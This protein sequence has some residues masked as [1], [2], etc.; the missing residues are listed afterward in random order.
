MLHTFGVVV[1]RGIA[2]GIDLPATLAQQISRRVITVIDHTRNAV[3]VSGLRRLLEQNIQASLERID[4]RSDNPALLRVTDPLKERRVRAIVD[5]IRE[6]IPADLMND[7]VRYGLPSYIPEDRNISPHL[8]VAECDLA[9]PR[10][11]KVGGTT[12]VEKCKVEIDTRHYF[13]RLDHDKPHA[14]PPT[15]IHDDLEAA[16]ITNAQTLSAVGIRIIAQP[17][18]EEDFRITNINDINA[19][20]NATARGVGLTKRYEIIRFHPRARRDVEFIIDTSKIV[21]HRNTAGRLVAG[22]NRDA[23]ANALRTNNNNILDFI[24]FQP[25]NAGVVPLTPLLANQIADEM[26]RVLGSVPTGALSVINN[27]VHVIQAEIAEQHRFFEQLREGSDNNGAATLAT[28]LLMRHKDLRDVLRPRD[29]TAI[30]RD[31]TRAQQDLTLI[32]LIENLEQSSVPSGAG[33]WQQMRQM[34]IDIQTAMRTAGAA[35]DGYIAFLLAGTVCADQSSPVELDP[36]TGT[37]NRRPLISWLQGKQNEVRAKI[38]EYEEIARKMAAIS[39][40]ITT[41]NNPPLSLGLSLGTIGTLVPVIT[42]NR[43]SYTSPM[44]LRSFA[45]DAKA[46]CN[47]VGKKKED[48]AKNLEKLNKELAEGATKKINGAEAQHRVI[49]AELMRYHGLTENEARSGA[50]VLRARALLDTD[51]TQVAARI[52]GD[53]HGEDVQV[54]GSAWEHVK[55]FGEDVMRADYGLSRDRVVI[56][57]IAHACHVPHAAHHRPLWSQT[58]RYDD[59]I[60]A[61]HAL[62]KLKQ[63]KFYDRNSEVPWDIRLRDAA[64]VDRA[65]QEISRALVLQHAKGILDVYGPSVGLTEGDKEKILA[66]PLKSQHE[67]ILRGFLEADPDANIAHKAQHAI[68]H[69]SRRTQPVRRFLSSTLFGKDWGMVTGASNPVSYR[70]LIYGNPTF[71]LNG[72]WNMIKNLGR[73][74]NSRKWGILAGASLGFLALGPAAPLGIAAAS[75]AGGKFWGKPPPAASAPSGSGAANH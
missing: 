39:A 3:E 40:Q 63:Q 27:P 72:G 55:R 67:R 7:V 61:Y 21:R 45:E 57:N 48:I 41:M 37:P 59:L 12:A 33:N 65:M 8:V 62:R 2:L 75:I 16:L 68:E 4:I 32:K 26:F 13:W 24:S 20:L 71:S 29:G 5:A 51:M 18:I 31:I 9:S 25:T 74:A 54:T 52:S 44:D 58:Q 60:T 23:L 14:T 11:Q 6:S 50:N 66:E 17:P 49:S 56:E 64:G 22:M 70:S 69:A 30:Q 10:F 38:A 46:N 19:I 36:N 73:N 43:A 47:L 53:L 1:P 28:S 34:E 15:N 35:P 42:T